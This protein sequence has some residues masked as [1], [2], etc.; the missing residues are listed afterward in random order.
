MTGN[1]QLRLAAV[2]LIATGLWP[3]L[4]PIFT[5][6][7]TDAVGVLP[8]LVVSGLLALG[9][10]RGWRWVAYLAFALVLFAAVMT[11]ATLGARGP[12]PGW[13]MWVYLVGLLIAAVALFRSLW[14]DR[15]VRD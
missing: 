5:G 15:A 4:T 13:F 1:T 9:L 10:L 6:R 14:A 12:V 7:I 11:A 2:M 8:P 3:L